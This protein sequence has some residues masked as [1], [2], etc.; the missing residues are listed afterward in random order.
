VCTGNLCRSP[1]AEAMLTTELKRRGCNEVE[2]RS[3]GTWA[4]GG[5]GAT[6]EAIATMANRHIDLSAHRSRALDAQEVRDADLIVAMTSAHIGEV[7][8]LEPSAAD[9]IILLKQISDVVVETD[10]PADA[11]ARL[12]GLLSAERPLPLRS[13][14]LDDPMGLPAGAYERCAS[15]LEVGIV[16]LADVLCRAESSAT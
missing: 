8:R 16:A 13:H 5:Q 2:V 1:M 6:Q 12:R 14:D 7:L 15:E 10:D 11:R 3:C 9:K 4:L